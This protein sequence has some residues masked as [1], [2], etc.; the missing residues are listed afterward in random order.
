M[1]PKCAPLGHTPAHS[2]VICRRGNRM[3]LI[4]KH[5]RQAFREHLV[6]WTLRRIS[7]LFDACDISRGQPSAI[8][9]GERRS[10]VEEYYAGVDWSSTREIRKM[11]RAYEEILTSLESDIGAGAYV[12]EQGRREL[13]KLTLLLKRDGYIY[14]HGRLS[15]V[16]GIDLKVVEDASNIVDRQS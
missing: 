16:V 3:D 4:S 13:Q 15:P 6:G 14:E 1:C 12:G 8:T 10:L 9:T 2:R 5:T 11:L 7:D